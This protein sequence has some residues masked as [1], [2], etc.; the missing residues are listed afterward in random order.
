MTRVLVVED[1][2]SFSGALSYMLRREGLEVAVYP[3]GPDALEAL[4]RAGADLVLLDLMLRR[5][6]GVEV[7]RTCVNGLDVPMIMLTDSEEDKAAGLGPGADHY[8]SK[9]FS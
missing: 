2:E 1:E 4:D 6:Q 8:V 3:T 9:P 7:C 5:P